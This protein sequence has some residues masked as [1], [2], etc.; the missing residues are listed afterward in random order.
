[1][2][3]I[4]TYILADIWRR[5]SRVW[6]LP[7]HRKNICWA[8]PR[9]TTLP[10]PPHPLQKSAGVALPRRYAATPIRWDC[11][12]AR[13]EGHRWAACRRGC[14]PRCPPHTRVGGD[15]QPAENFSNLIQGKG[16]NNDLVAYLWKY[17]RIFQWFNLD[18]LKNQYVKHYLLDILR[19]GMY[20]YSI[21]TGAPLLDPCGQLLWWWGWLLTWLQWWQGW[22]RVSAAWR[23]P[24]Q[25]D[26]ASPT[27]C[28]PRD[29][30]HLY[31]Q[32]S[33][34]R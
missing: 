10:A 25:R 3:K 28:P 21:R 22:W 30:R 13:A 14:L 12:T 4:H 33:F 34:I 23:T 26:S 8:P 9:K 17:L 7:L 31:P 15:C 18:F 6:L 24:R 11:D 27:P 29:S 2:T 1:M 32:A 20:E 19:L 5:W 16:A